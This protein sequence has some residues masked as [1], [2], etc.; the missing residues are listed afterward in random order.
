MRLKETNLVRVFNNNQGEYLTEFKKDILHSL[1]QLRLPENLPFLGIAPCLIKPQKFAIL[2]DV[3][4]Q[5]GVTIIQP[6][7][8][9]RSQIRTIN[10]ERYNRC[11]I[12]SSE[13]SERLCV[14]ELHFPISIKELFEKYHRALFI[15][16]NEHENKN[17][18]VS[19]VGRNFE[20]TILIVGP[21]GGF[22]DEELEF[23]SNSGAYSISL[24]KNILRTETAVAA[25]ISQLM[26]IRTQ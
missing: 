11:L 17:G 13:Q 21:E 2:L 6:L 8:G 10:Y 14:P 18:M 26:V 25:I 23:L 3:S 22:S 20:N 15:Y 16:A 1:E 4:T 5:L 7:I 24:G 12:E 19:L 9:A